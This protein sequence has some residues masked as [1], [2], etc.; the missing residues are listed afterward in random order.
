MAPG[1]GIFDP[2]IGLEKPWYWFYLSVIIG[3]VL[4]VF[5]IITFKTAWLRRREKKEQEKL[6]QVDDK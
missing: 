1:I 4:N 3:L 6:A 2:L 5:F